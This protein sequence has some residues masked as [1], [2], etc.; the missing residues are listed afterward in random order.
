MAA[1][2]EL[3]AG[4]HA[5]SEALIAGEPIKSVIVARHRER[6]AALKDIIGAAV[7]EPVP[8][9]RMPQ[10]LFRNGLPYSSPGLRK[11]DAGS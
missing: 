10:S 7:A 1:D 8:R 2:E 5:V 4:V 3:I 11:A 6:D 9:F